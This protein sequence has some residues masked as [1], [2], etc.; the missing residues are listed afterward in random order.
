MMITL[1]SKVWKFIVVCLKCLVSV[2]YM[3]MH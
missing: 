2:T 3:V 1:K